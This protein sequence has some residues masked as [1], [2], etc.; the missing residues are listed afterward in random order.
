MMGTS[1]FFSLLGS[2]SAL[3]YQQYSEDYGHDSR[4]LESEAPVWE[5]VVVS[6]AIFVMLVVICT[7]YIGPDWVMVA[8]NTLFMATGI[9]SV[10]EGLEGFSNNSILTIMVLLLIGEGLGRTGALDYYMSKMLGKPKTIV[11]AQIRLMIPTGIISAFI[12]N[13]A[14]VAVM[15]PLVLRWARATGIPRQQL[16]MPLSFVTILGGTCTLIGTSSNLVVSGLLSEDFPDDPVGNIGL[17]DLGLIGVPNMLIGFI[18][19]VLFCPYLLPYGDRIPSTNSEPVL[20]GARVP[21]WSP[22]VG[23]AVGKSG[24]SNSGGIYLV[25]VRSAATGNMENAVSKDFVL[26]VGDE[27]YFTGSV[28]EFAV[29]CERHGLEI[30]T[31]EELGLGKEINDIGTTLRSIVTSDDSALHEVIEH[32]SEQI[33]GREPVESGS[34]ATR[35]IV[36]SDVSDTEGGL[37]VG[38]DCVD[39]PRLLETI[40]SAL[41]QVGLKHRNSGAAVYGE[42][43]LSIWRCEP[44]EYAS[45]ERVDVWTVLTDSLNESIQAAGETKSGTHV[46]R[47]VVTKGSTFIGKQPGSVD[48]RDAYKATIV[49]YQKEGKNAS[50]DSDMEADDVLVLQVLA[51]SPLLLRPPQ[52]F[53]KAMK[54]GFLSR[55]FGSA[56]TTSLPHDSGD[57]DYDEI[58]KVWK[59]LKVVFEDNDESDGDIDT[60]GE[61]LTAFVVTYNSPLENKS[62]NELGFGSLAGAVLVSI[63]RND[64]KSAD[65]ASREALSPNDRLTV[66]DILWIS[67]SGT[68]IAGLQTMRGLEYFEM[69]QVKKAERILQNRRLV[70]AVVARGSPLVGKTVTEACFRSVYGGAVIALQRGNGR[71]HEH[72][73]NVKL[74][75]G[76]ALLIQAGPSF[77]KHNHNKY[78]TFALVSEVEDSSS[79][80]PRW[81]LLCVLMIVTIL[82][83]ASLEISNLLIT[84]TIVGIVTVGLGVVTQQE[85][86]DCLQWDLYLVLACAFGIG[87]AMENS[88]VAEGLATFMVDISIALGDVGVYG[89]VYLATMLLSSIL[90]NNAAAALMYPIAMAAVEQTGADR[91]KMGY[92]V[93]LAAND[94]MTSFGYQTNMMVY[95]PGGYTS[96][97]YLRFGGPQFLLWPTSVALVT[98]PAK[99][100][101]NWFICFSLFGAV[102]LVRLEAS[103]WTLRKKL[104][105]QAKELDEEVDEEGQVEKFTTFAA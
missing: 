56:S 57:K 31:T 76:D 1:S 85:A 39:R 40:S 34:R 17:F 79:P 9:I 82:V 22:S 55:L 23:R 53:Y 100:Y 43:S 78:K 36:T 45:V 3:L 87:T 101:V 15:V 71:V 88:G 62:T 99:W 60:N 67:G 58:Q 63:E 86:R 19:I 64:Y 84:A 91:L 47:A 41:L 28:E 77:Y 12:S 68:S 93:M 27:L 16:M 2:G 97:D 29:F 38:V 11:D 4:Q 74:E 8:T 66:G 6:I 96:M 83:L 18:Y 70:E 102:C 25:H 105:A 89:A 54:R 44:S 20:L 65:G 37:V 103:A 90:T 10:K 51:D 69:D 33:A 30:I 13:T 92:M 48:F 35:V 49:A 46:V 21:S 42:R 95:R 81:F 5:A 50:L 72:P 80:R 26:S 52:G 104:K 7:D 75:A 59:D 98:T 14:Q 24:V 73:S 94:Y 32:L 61:F